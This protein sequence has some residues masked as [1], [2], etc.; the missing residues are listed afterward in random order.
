MNDEFYIG[1][2]DRAPARIRRVIKTLIALFVIIVPALAFGLGQFQRTIG[3]SSFEWGNVKE[4]AGIFAASPYPH[5]MVPRPGASGTNSSYSSYYLVRPF[6]FGF[7]PAAAARLDGQEVTL[8]GTLIHREG[9]TMIEV[10]DNSIRSIAKSAL[11]SLPVAKLGR[12]TLVG[13]IVDSKC[14]LGVMN[15]G[16]FIPHRAC[17]IRCLSGGIPPILVVR[18]RNGPNLHFLLVSSDGRAVN[19]RILDL[20]AEP[21]EVTGEVERQG[22]LLILRA[23]PSTYRRI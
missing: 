22:D 2:Q 19:D 9:Q 14:Y 16:E 5:L 13:E 1:W 11:P 17:A 3:K 21:V 23:D 4:F 7:D 10:L 15:P 6:K 20:V 12:Q 8:R 18:Q